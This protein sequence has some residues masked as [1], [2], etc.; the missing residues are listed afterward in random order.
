LEGQLGDHHN[1]GSAT[2]I[3]RLLSWL[4]LRMRRSHPKADRIKAYERER[5]RLY[6]DRKR[7][8]LLSGTCPGHVP[9]SPHREE[10]KIQEKYKKTQ[11]HGMAENWRP[12]D[13]GIQ[14]GVRAF[15]ADGIEAAID[16][17]R[18]T[19][20][21][22]PERLTDRQWEAKWR[23]WCRLHIAPSLP[24]G[25]QLASRKSAQPPGVTIKQFS[26]QAEAWEKYNGKSFPWGRYGIWRVPTEW[27]P[28]TE[29]PTSAQRRRE[30]G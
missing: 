13:E 26:P 20:L 3:A 19:W 27:P 16:R 2:M 7:S 17:H 18:D 10:S 25:P 1:T 29:A 4:R 22:R 21:S 24:L 8:E 23:A 11:A 9:D 14:L 15:R 12:D 6:R 28:A 5:K 30:N